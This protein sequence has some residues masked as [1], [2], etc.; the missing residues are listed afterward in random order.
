MVDDGYD[1]VP[2]R[3][4]GATVALVA[5]VVTASAAVAEGFRRTAQWAV[6]LYAGTES[7]T[8]AADELSPVLVAA[9]VATAV[10]VAA[11][12]GRRA[13]R[14]WPGASG[15]EAVAASARGEPRRISAT[16]TSD[17]VA[18]IWAVA[19]GLVSI[20]RETA[21]IEAG[22]AV[23]A[24]AG[25]RTGGKGDAMAVAGIA[26]AFAAAYHAP[27]AAMVYV[28]EHLRVRGSG[29]AVRF[30]VAGAVGGHLV[31]VG[32]LG[33]DALFPP[34]EG[35]R[36]ALLIAGLA[37]AVPAAMTARVF[38]RLRTAAAAD[39]WRE[40]LPSAG[41]HAVVVTA[42]L[43][44]GLAVA[45]AP[46]A[47]GNGMDGLRTVP[48]SATVGL[49]VALV[50]G[51]IVGTTAA[52]AAGA[53]GGVISPSM[54]IAGGAALLVALGADAAGLAVDHPWDIV[55]AAMVVGVA[56]G[57]RS[58]IMA[59][60]LVAELLGDYTLVPALAVVALAAYAI[61]RLV[62]LVTRSRPSD[63]V[64]DEDA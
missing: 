5:L 47:A 60:L 57:L 20:G 42:A 38:L 7:S 33:G 2:D 3:P 50:V 21:I 30:T 56:V 1:T 10:L 45:L 8:A 17:R 36:W 55:V 32:L 51:K 6:E 24:K 41:R 12:L 59:P 31:A 62:D 9:L 19:A 53:P 52:L 23:G 25:R 44:A 16:A 54:A 18:A 43:V 14:R 34:L 27:L 29:R 28:E 35:S 15:L 64:H 40:R 63:K 13:S 61:D 11:A 37:V 48:V 58:P 46:D 39:G 4:V 26:A 22:G 49:A